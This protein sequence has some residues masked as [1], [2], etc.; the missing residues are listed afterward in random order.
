MRQLSPLQKIAF[1]KRA[2]EQGR[3]VARH[4]DGGFSSDSYNGFDSPGGWGESFTAGGWN[5]ENYGSNFSGNVEAVNSG[6]GSWDYNNGYVTGYTPSAWG[7][8]WGDQGW[9]MNPAPA[10]VQSAPAPVQSAPAPAPT[11]APAPQPTPRPADLPSPNASPMQGVMAGLDL[12]PTTQ[13]QI[14]FSNIPSYDLDMPYE[15]PSQQLDAYGDDDRGSAYG[16]NAGM[17]AIAG[18]ALASSANTYGDDDR[19]SAYG[20]SSSRSSSR[21]GQYDAPAS[22]V[23]FDRGWS[24]PA[25]M[26]GN[27]YA[28]SYNDPLGG[29]GESMYSDMVGGST[30]NYGGSGYAGNAPPSEASQ[31]SY[32]TSYDPFAVDY[33]G[34]APASNYSL[35]DQFNPVSAA[36]AAA[37][38]GS[39]QSIGFPGL[40]VDIGQMKPGSAYGR[41]ATANAQPIDGLV[42]HH[43]GPG[44]LPNLVSYAQSPGIHGQLGYHA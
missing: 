30:N 21:S 25:D 19:G 27:D 14:D 5:G 37:L 31:T 3:P 36:Q 43:T 44:S 40:D 15:Q 35:L 26:A 18:A 20:G 8:E 22:S 11:P 9:S 29:M 7:Q 1:M 6:G 28:T 2:Q 10:P 23:D 38:T 17:A 34:I 33:N 12:T 39:P 13:R 4:W 32:E 42:I 24:N 16:A 41:Y